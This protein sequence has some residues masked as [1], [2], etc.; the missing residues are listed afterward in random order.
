VP[1]G[2][3]SGIVAQTSERAPVK[4]TAGVCAGATRTAG[5]PSVIQI[6]NGQPVVRLSSANG[7]LS[8]QPAR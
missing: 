2:Y 3:A 1:D 7:P 6:G 4:C 8:I 5:S